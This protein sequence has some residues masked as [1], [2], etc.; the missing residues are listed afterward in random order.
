[1]PIAVTHCNT[2]AAHLL[3]HTVLHRYTVI[4]SHAGLGLIGRSQGGHINAAVIHV[5]VV[6]IALH[7][8]DKQSGKRNA[9]QGAPIPGYHRHAGAVHL[10]CSA[11]AFQVG[12]G[13]IVGD[14]QIPQHNIFHIIEQHGGGHFSPIYMAV[15]IQRRAV[16][17]VPYTGT[18]CRNTRQ[19]IARTVSADLYGRAGNIAAVFQVHGLAGK[20]AAPL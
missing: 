11:V 8:M 3:D 15:K 5:L 9:V 4:P 1:M 18:V 14:L 12:K 7:I 10:V 13:R 17:L 16:I 2:P 6:Y 20:H 19:G